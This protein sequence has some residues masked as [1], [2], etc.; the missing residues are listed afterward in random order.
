MNF[1]KGGENDPMFEFKYKNCTINTFKG[2]GSPEG[3]G[4]HILKRAL[5]EF[6]RAPLLQIYHTQKTHKN[7]RGQKTCVG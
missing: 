6:E 3:Q 2:A 1:K 4:G 7:G 5:W